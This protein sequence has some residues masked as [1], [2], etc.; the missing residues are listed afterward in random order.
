MIKEILEFFKAIFNNPVLKNDL[1]RYIRDGQPQNIGDVERLER[2][3]AMQ[4]RHLNT[5]Y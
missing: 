3:F 4:R 1:E 2:E 5:Y